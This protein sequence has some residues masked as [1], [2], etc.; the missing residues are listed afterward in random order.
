MTVD[1][2]VRVW[3]DEDGWGVVDS[4]GTPGGCW[5]HYSA[6][7]VAGFRSLSP[8]QAVRLEFEELDFL[9]DGYPYRAVRVWPVGQ[10]P[11]EEPPNR[12]RDLG[13]TSALLPRM[14]GLRQPGPADGDPGGQ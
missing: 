5:T 8:G 9:Q 1:G 2:V 3:H 6:V 11:H 13:Y 14:D 7:A 4:D 10:E 12:T